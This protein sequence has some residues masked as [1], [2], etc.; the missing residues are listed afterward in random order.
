MDCTDDIVDLVAG[1]ETLAPHFHLPLQHGADTV[2]TRMRRPYTAGFFRGLVER[3]HETMPHAAIGSDLI[4]GFPGESADEFSETERMLSDL[5][6]SHLHVFPYSD[7]PGTE[8]SEMAG[9]VD[10]VAIRERGARLRE[11]GRAMVA[12]FRD[13]QRGTVRRALTVDDGRSAVTDNYIKVSLDPPQ[14]RNTWIS[15]VID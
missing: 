3:I 7:R 11:I 14:A 8:A 10:G 9:K 13:T 2:L 12:R 5:P 4:V 1:A 6:L 15:A